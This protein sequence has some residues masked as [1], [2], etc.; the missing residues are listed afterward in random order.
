MSELPKGWSVACISDLADLNPKQTFDD[1]MAAGFVPMSHA[2]TNFRDKLRF[3][4]RS[5]GDI[6]K[7]YTNF[8]DG[9]VIFA[10]VTPCFENG[11]AAFVQG[12]PNGIGAGSSEFFV[13]RPCNEEISAKYLLALVK[14]REFMREGALNMT[15]A[16]GLRRVP[17]QFVE[18]Y[19]VLVP[20]ASEQIR[21][22]QKLDELLAQVDTLKARIDTIPA[23][24]RRFRQS[25]L[26]AAI[27]GQLTREW[28]SLHPNRSVFSLEQLVQ[29]IKTSDFKPK[30]KRFE[31]SQ[32]S[33]I[34]GWLKIPLGSVF[35]V[36]S[37]DGLTAKEMDISGK[38]PVYGGNGV[39]GQHTEHNITTRT[40]VIGRVGYY[41][42]SVH[43]TPSKAWVTDNALIVNY[44]EALFNLNY[45]YWLLL[46]TNLRKNT[47]SSAQPVISGEKI[48]PIG[49]N[50]A[51]LE[52]QTEIV[53]RI[54]QL[55][56]LADQLEA[57]V[58][59]AKSRIDHLTQSIL[60]KAFRG[61]LVPQ[62]PNDEPA[63]VLLERIKEQR[64][65]A[66]KTKRGR[67]AT[68]SDDSR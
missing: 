68:T 40:V 27:S 29:C 32:V 11:K 20:P 48:Y 51:P 64:A 14:S 30:A 47:S 31:P 61:E 41:C 35:S 21:I 34:P 49:L 52:E 58:A 25:V 15:G 1:H 7:A 42:G 53:R 36:K 46:G 3:D 18:Q 45:I 63:S 66:P 38:I 12:L 33:E 26:A 9:D 8:K 65:A 55:F 62:D 6:K 56:A 43:F 28:R 10:K 19:P 57:K 16:V 39:N 22:A 37:G 59:S 44:P 17:K 23:L 24:L 54:E 50:I 13:L 5:W 67:K 4:E 60:S 2:P